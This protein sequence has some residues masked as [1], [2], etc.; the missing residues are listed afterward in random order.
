MNAPVDRRQFLI[1]MP[2]LLAAPRL[3]AQASAPQLKV[4]AINHVTVV[5]SDLDAFTV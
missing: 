1:S 5:V 2:A 4:R 3:L